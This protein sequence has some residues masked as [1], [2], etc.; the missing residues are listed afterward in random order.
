MKEEKIYTKIQQ[1]SSA[2]N[3]ANNNKQNESKII[4]ENIAGIPHDFVPI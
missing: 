1:N 4:K 2:D 3:K